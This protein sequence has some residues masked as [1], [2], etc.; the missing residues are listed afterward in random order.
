MICSSSGAAAKGF[1]RLLTEQEILKI[2][3]TVAP[4]D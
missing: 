1:E 4:A 2:V 3:E